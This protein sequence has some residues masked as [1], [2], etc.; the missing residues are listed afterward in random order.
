MRLS[1]C[2]HEKDGQKAR[3]WD[4]F[5]REIGDALYECAR[6]ELPYPEL[7][8][9]IYQ[10]SEDA[11]SLEYNPA[12]IEDFTFDL[13]D[14]LEIQ[15]VAEVIDRLTTLLDNYCVSIGH[16]RFEFVFG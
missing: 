9:D 11:R 12:R 1:A 6:Q 10:L 13:M 2:D 4:D 15:G 5:R 14:H 16:F 8:N 7:D 3:A